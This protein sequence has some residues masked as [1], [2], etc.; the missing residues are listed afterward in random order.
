MTIWYK[1][2]YQLLKGSSALQYYLFK[3]E[4]NSSTLMNRSLVLCASLV[5]TSNGQL[6]NIEYV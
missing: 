6:Q 5:F 4:Q 3:A 2:A 1:L